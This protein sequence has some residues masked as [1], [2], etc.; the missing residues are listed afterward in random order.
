[1]KTQG[2]NSA[3]SILRG[4]IWNYKKSIVLYIIVVLVF[5][6]SLLSLMP[7]GLED[8]WL[9]DIAYHFSWECNGRM[10]S[11]IP[12]G[13][14]W[15]TGIGKMF[16]FVHYICYKIIGL[17]LF[18]ARLVTFVSG[19]VLLVYLY[20]WTSRYVSREIALLSTF[21]LTIST[22]FYY[23]LTSTRSDILFCLLSFLSFY[24]ISSAVLTKNDR[25]FLYAGFLST[26]SVDISWRAIEIVLV[27]YLFH[28]IYFN[29]KSFFKRSL[30]LITGSFVAFVYW[31]S[32]NILPIGISNFL[33]YNLSYNESGFNVFSELGKIANHLF[34]G[35]TGKSLFAI[36]EAV[37]IVGLLIIFY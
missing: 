33:K 30:L 22:T 29:R 16:F 14:N 23:H 19:I 6:F 9:S 17:G 13:A 36:V 1:M 20:K 4:D 2:K 11:D 32:V 37:Y 26:L 31:L 27:V 21:L 7:P 3:V 18:Q 28:C 10:A 15:S 35:S 12:Y 25:Y 8:G 34:T 5:P 24:L